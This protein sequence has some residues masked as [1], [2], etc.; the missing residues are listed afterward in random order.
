MKKAAQIISQIIFLV[1]F[2]VLVATGKMQLWMAVF[3]L[4]VLLSIFLGRLYCGWACPINTVMIAVSWVKKKLK[5]KS[6]NTPKL[7]KK[8]WIRYVVLGLFVASFAFVMVSGKKLPVLPGL[9]AIGV[10]LT[11]FFPEEFWHRYL[12]P[13]GTILSLVSSKSMCS[14]RVDEQVC[15]NCGVCKSVCPAEAIVH[16]DDKYTIK[17]KD[18]L[19]CLECQLK[20][21]VNAITYKGK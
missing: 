13:Y 8:Q 3:V 4:G 9:L 18:C 11:F 16:E 6:F 1:L 5:I 2:T 10:L 20:C 7:F 21:K 19:I 15:I 17:K 12:C 14:V